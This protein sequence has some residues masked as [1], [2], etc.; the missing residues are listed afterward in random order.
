[1]FRTDMGILLEKLAPFAYEE[2]AQYPLFAS[3]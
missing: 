1:M 3:F 2:R